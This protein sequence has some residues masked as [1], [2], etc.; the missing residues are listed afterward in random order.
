MAQ[1]TAGQ[2]DPGAQADPGADADPGAQ[3]DP[4]AVLIAPTD[5]GS[6]WPSEAGEV[7][8]PPDPAEAL[9]ELAARQ[10][11]LDAAAVQLDAGQ[12]ELAAQE[13]TLELGRQLADFADQVRAVSPDGSTAVA[14]V[15]YQD[16]QFAL[17]QASKTEVMDILE[18]AELEGARVDFS[19]EIAQTTEGLLG[20]GE[21]LGVGVAAIVLLVALRMVFAAALPIITSVIGAG[22]G[23]AG[24]L[25]LSGVVEMSSITPVLG[26][27]LGLAVGIDYALFIV[28]RHRR[29]LR[30]GLAVSESIALATGTAGNAVVFAGTTVVIALAALNVCG[31]PFLGVMGWVGAVSVAIAVLVALTLVPA[32]LSLLGLRL[33]PKAQ[34]VA[35]AVGSA[36]AADAAGAAGSVDPARSAGAAGS[37]DPARSAGAAGAAGSLD[38]ARSADAAESAGAAG[39]AG[40]LDP[41]RSAAPADAVAQAAQAGQGETADQ[42]DP[43]ADLSHHPAEAAARL[44]PMPTWRAAGAVVIGIVGL[45]LVATPI[46]TM[47][48]G[49]PDGSAEPTDSTSYRAFTEVAEQFGPGDNG[50]L[51]VAAEL[52]APLAAEDQLAAQVKIAGE[53]MAQPDVVA[54]APAGVAAEGDYLAFQVIPAEGPASASTEELVR[55]LRALTPL[56]GGIELGVAGQA[57]GN[58]DISAKLADALPLYLAVVVGLSLVILMTVFRSVLVPVIAAAGFVLSYLAA[59]GAVVAIYQWGWLSS[60]FAVHDPG[61]VLNFVP[62]LL[63]G[64]IFG[65]AMDYQL[66]LVSGMRE[67]H[68]HGAPARQAVVAGLHGGRAV[69]TAAALIMMAVFGGFIFSHLA[70]VRP[71]GFGLAVGVMFDA[72]VV[73]LLVVP[74]LMH[75]AGRAAWWLPRWLDRLLPNV[76]VEGAALRRPVA[77]AS[78]QPNR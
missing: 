11:E 67:A 49:L 16:S 52:P 61:P 30:A 68:V 47:R 37:L 35:R 54:V 76:D 26:I 39:A 56:D 2:T 75:L 43:P 21:V 78:A 23:V 7:V 53:L 5:P 18:A 40:S 63:V 46:W 41:A 66:F 13:E 69:V 20:L 44:R 73:R 4:S 77:V 32:L 14:A 27:M 31:I 22:I 3:G 6:L 38:P 10:A 57:S 51:V 58:I 72:F 12:A 71:L 42:P 19:A 62:L 8:V 9:A 59:L 24:S 25:S 1:A 64:V 15:M 33:L 29:S 70:L 55:R 50:P 74:G 65:L 45:S 28:L 36:D 48:L 17:P 60:V 34:R